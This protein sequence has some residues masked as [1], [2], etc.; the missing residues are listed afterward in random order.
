[1]LTP[2]PTHA[3]NPHPFPSPASARGAIVVLMSLRKARQATQH[4]CT[5]AVNVTVG[6][7]NLRQGDT[8]CSRQWSPM[9]T[10]W[11][12]FPS[13]GSSLLYCSKYG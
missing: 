11:L 12:P 2:A 4:L 6:L 3:S 1:M 9:T 7:Y 8:E 10:Q 5:R 13:T